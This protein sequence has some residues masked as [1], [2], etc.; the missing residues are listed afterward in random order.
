MTLSHLRYLR[1]RLSAIFT[2]IILALGS[3]APSAGAAASSLIEIAA[4]HNAVCWPAAH[5]RG[6]IVALHGFTQDAR[7]FE[8]LASRL[9]PLGFSFVS[10]DL[11]AHGNRY[12]LPELTGHHKKL[13]YPQSAD[14]MLVL[15]AEMK[16]S[17]PHLPPFFLS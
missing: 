13:S 11:R 10:L 12:H 9:T 5:Q 4:R 15:A 6:I 14:D 2:V 17:Y 3:T 16:K 8:S 1:L 7:C